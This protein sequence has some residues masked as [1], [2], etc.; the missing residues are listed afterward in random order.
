MDDRTIQENL[1]VIEAHFQGEAA[2]EI[3]RILPHYTDDV[4]W[5]SPARGLTLHGK[6]AAAEN[7]RQMFGGMEN[8][9]FTRLRRFATADRVVDDSIATFTLVNGG[10]ANA[11]L[12]VGSLV[13]LRL[14]HIFEMRDHKIARESVYETWRAISQSAAEPVPAAGAAPRPGGERRDGDHGAGADHRD[15]RAGG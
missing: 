7:Y 2:N 10:V 6:Q 13:E 12:P 9:E 5:E 1:A 15:G 4:V 11:P 14:V 8:I 3:Y